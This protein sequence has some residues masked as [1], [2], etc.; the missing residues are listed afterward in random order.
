MRLTLLTLLLCSAQ[1][2]SAQS[3]HPN[4]CDGTRYKQAVFNTVKKTTVQY[5][6]TPNYF[7]NAMTLSMDV[8]EPEGDQATER[9]VIVLAHGGSFIIGDRTMMEAYCQNMAKRGYVAAT[10]QY[11][12]YPLLQLGFPD[13]LDIF[14]AAVKAVADMRAAVRYFRQDAASTNVFRADP[15]H[16][17]IGGYSAG[18]VTALHAAYMDPEDDVPTFLLNFI[19]ANGGWT[20]NSGSSA[21]QSYSADVEAVINM[22]GGLYRSSWIDA[23][24]VS[25]S[26]IHGTAD[27]TVSYTYGLAAGLAYLEGSSLL[28]VRAQEIGLWNNLVTV[29][30]GG[31]STTY[32]QAAYAPQVNNFLNITSERLEALTCAVSAADDPQQYGDRYWSIAPNPA[33][34]GAQLQVKLPA[35]TETAQLTLYDLSGRLLQQ[36]RNVANEQGI[37]LPADLVPGIKFLHIENAPDAP[38][39]RIVVE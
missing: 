29:Q 17:F 39:F 36:Y 19:N 21:N 2:L 37:L 15:D 25:L 10:I 6:T 5:A 11:R 14:D 24:E 38:L 30:G 4:A 27:E 18:A 28:H 12:L 16:I 22:S 31:H 1:I 34:A 33:K 9:P 26:S 23:D 7:G 8:Y 32:E 35:G 3:P 13:S 20:G